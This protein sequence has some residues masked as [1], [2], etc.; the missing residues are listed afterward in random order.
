M[1]ALFR[2]AGADI[3]ITGRVADAALFLAPLVHEFGWAWDDWDRLAAGVLVGQDGFAAFAVPFDRTTNFARRP[4]HEAVLGVLPTFGAKAAPHI[5]GNDTDLVF[6][7]FKN[8]FGQGIADAVRVLHVGPDGVALFARV[9]LG[10]YSTRLHVMGIDTADHVTP[11]DHLVGL[12]ESGFGGCGIALLKNMREIV[13]ALVPNCRSLPLNQLLRIG[14]AGQGLII[15]FDL[16]GG[17]FGLPQGLG[18]DQYHWIAH[19]FDL[20]PAEALM[21]AGEHRTAIGSLARQIHFH[22]AQTIGGHIV[23]RENRHDAW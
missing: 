23:T 22:G 5:V 8:I 9:V 13:R 12:G 1:A 2:D 17:I 7:D 20:P 15:N 10:Q 14:H 6:G 11:L 16:F 19:I 4:R 3:V 21:L 18:D